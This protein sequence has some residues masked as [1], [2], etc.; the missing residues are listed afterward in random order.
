[1]ESRRLPFGSKR[2]VCVSDLSP[3]ISVNE[4]VKWALDS[5][6]GPETLNLVPS[7][8]Y[9]CLSVRPVKIQINTY[10][11]VSLGTETFIVGFVMLKECWFATRCRT[12]RW[13]FPLL[14]LPVLNHAQKILMKKNAQTSKKWDTPQ[15]LPPSRGRSQA[16]RWRRSEAAAGR[17]ALATRPRWWRR[18]SCC[19][20]SRS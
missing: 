15:L 18:P 3:D 9:R 2:S 12:I 7:R 20:S 5:L 17:P 16:A 19:P 8:S 14:P 4:A 6:S 10:L 13:C 11:F 1:M